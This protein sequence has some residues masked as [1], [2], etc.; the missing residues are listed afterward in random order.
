VAVAKLEA[1]DLDGAERLLS[2]A[3]P[4]GAELRQHANS[5][6]LLD[7][8]MRLH[9]ARGRFR[10]CLDDAAELGKRAEALGWHNPGF[11]PWRSFAAVCLAALGEQPARARRLAAEEVELGRRWGAPQALGVA[12]RAQALVH[13]SHTG[14]QHLREAVE[15]LEGS[16]FRLEHARALV[17]LGALL[18]RGGQRTEARPPLRTG[19]DLARACGATPLAE[20]AYHELRATGA[21]P[22]KL[23][24]TGLAS[25]TPSERR[26]AQMAAAGKTNKQIA[27][28]LYV[29][30]KTVE[31]HLAAAYR[32][33]DITTRAQLESKLAPGA[34]VS[35]PAAAA[36]PAQ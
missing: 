13:D 7:G 20:R 26:I 21:S 29:T 19:L 5:L 9:L 10:A 14:E 3:A 33:L 4:I 23:T 36:A 2:S 22:R 12:L 30:A 35:Q 18:R 34:P 16:P 31:S 27:Q 17:E 8:R 32:K 25:L 24:R 1:G 11:M 15:I 28:E 6:A